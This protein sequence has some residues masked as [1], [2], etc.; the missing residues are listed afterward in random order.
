[1]RY[2]SWTGTLPLT[3]VLDL[4]DVLIDPQPSP[5]SWAMLP[6]SVDTVRSGRA[7]EQW[8]IA[9][10]LGGSPAFQAFAQVL[11]HSE[12]YGLVR[13]LLE[14]GTRSEGEEVGHGKFAVVCSR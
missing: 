12:S 9:Q 5:G 10:A 1:M 7:L 14:Q 11:R 3:N 8:Y 2:Y 4:S 6:V 13:F